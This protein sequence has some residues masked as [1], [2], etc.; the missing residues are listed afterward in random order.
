MYIDPLQVGLGIS[1]FLGR[2][3]SRFWLPIGLG[4]LISFLLAS[5]WRAFFLFAGIIYITDYLDVVV[6]SIAF[7]KLRHYRFV[8]LLQTGML[9][10]V[11]KHGRFC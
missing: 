2:P 7:V 5:F 10:V 6:C 3:R 11:C 9:V 8:G 4:G 1:I